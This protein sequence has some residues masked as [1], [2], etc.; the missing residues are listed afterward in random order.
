MNPKELNPENME[1]ISGGLLT[2]ENMEWLVRCMRTA[3][4]EGAT[5]EQFIAFGGDDP[6]SIEF[7]RFMWDKI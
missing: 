7:C 3:K 1:H 4:S 5:L 2:Q 6:Q